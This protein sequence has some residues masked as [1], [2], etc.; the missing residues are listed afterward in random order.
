MTQRL[1][2]RDLLAVDIGRHLR[3]QGLRVRIPPFTFHISSSIPIV[4]EGVAAVYGDYESPDEKE[5][6]ADFHVSVARVGHFVNPRC[7]FELDGERPFTPLAVGEAFA[8]LEWGMNWCVTGY[9]H[10]YLTLHSAVLERNGRVVLLPAPPGSGKSTLCAALSRSGWR[11]FSDEMALIDID[12]GLVHPFPRPISLKNR[13]IELMRSRYPEARFSPMAHDTLKGTVAHMAAPSSAIDHAYRLAP[14]G[15]I[16]FPRYRAG[17]PAELV[18][19]PKAATAMH[20][21]ENSFNFTVHGKAG[22]H[23]ISQLVNSCLCFDFAYG[24]LDEAIGV[25]ERLSESR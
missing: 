10:R 8:F 18:G 9:A 23:R 17:A 13:S 5:S 24:D 15:W 16:V 25:F 2:V 4:A 3:Q 19:R 1:L 7:A 14:A 22:L 20:L 6:C 12:N 11:L 21:A